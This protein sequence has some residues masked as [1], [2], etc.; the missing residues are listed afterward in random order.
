M[1]SE[2]THLGHG[3]VKALLQGTYDC[4]DDHIHRSIRRKVESNLSKMMDID[5]S[6]LV[7]LLLSQDLLTKDETALLTAKSE[8]HSHSVLHFFDILETKGPLAHLKFVHCLSQEMSHPA[9]SEL[10]KLLCQTT[11]EERLLC[12]KIDESALA[13]CDTGPPKRKPNRL[14]MEGALAQKKYKRLFAK[15]KKDLYSGDWIAVERGV[16]KCMQSEIPEVRVVGLLENAFSW[17]VRCNNEKVLEIIDEAKELCETKVSKNNAVFLKARAK[18]ILS[19]MYRYEQNDKAVKC[20]EKAMALLFNAE[21]GEDSAHANYNHACA[22]VAK[23]KPSDAAQIMS[24]FDFAADVGLVDQAASCC[25]NK[26]SQIVADKS[27]IH[28]AMLLLDLNKNA[29]GITDTTRQ[30]NITKA[31][32]TISELNVPSLCNRNK[33]L[34][35]LA[36]SELHTQRQNVTSAIKAARDAQTLATKC[37]FTCLLHLVN[38]K[39]HSLQLLHF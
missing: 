6:S 7:P 13:V 18:Y 27:L 25:S 9:H 4:I 5:L 8:V 16:D 36:E 39:L 12:Q 34:Y 11:D 21:P 38:A 31:C 30:E 17:V 35:Y 19:G 22:L 3:Y 26:W 24:K 28:K 15:I 14:V 23:G 37:D 2:T 20:A 29:P 32:S 1:Q 10:Y 33:C